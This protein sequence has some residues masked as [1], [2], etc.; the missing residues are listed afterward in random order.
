MAPRSASEK[1]LLFVRLG[2]RKIVFLAVTRRKNEP[3]A[4]FYLF[5]RCGVMA[6]YVF[7]ENVFGSKDRV[8]RRK[9]WGSALLMGNLPLFI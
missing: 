2:V 8:E 6:K 3:E 5:P 4:C 1:E 7:I 9:T